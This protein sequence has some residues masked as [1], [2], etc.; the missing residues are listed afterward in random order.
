[1]V[2]LLSSFFGYDQKDAQS[3]NIASFLPTAAAS[4][5]IHIKNREVE[6]K[7][8][9]TVALAGLVSAVILALVASG[10]DSAI[11]KKIFGGLVTVT[12]VIELCC[13]DKSAK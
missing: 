13:Q 10:V 2:V 11:I 9:L 5:A 1:M 12:G 3:I 7:T 8:A 6:F 4:L